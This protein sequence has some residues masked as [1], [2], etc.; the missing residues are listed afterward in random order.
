MRI[1]TTTLC[2]LTG[3]WIQ[4]QQQQFTTNGVF[5]V[6]AGVTSISVELVGPGGNGKV[7]GGGGGGGGGYA[8]GTFAVVPGS[9]LAIVVGSGGSDTATSMASL[10]ISAGAGGNA[11]SVPNPN[12]GGG[13]SGGQG[14]GG[15]VVHDGGAGGGGYWTYFGGG[16]GGAAGPDADGTAGGN[17]VA[18]NGANCLTPGG[19]GGTGGG[20]PAGNGGKGAGF[21]D[22]ACNATNPAG[23]GITYGGGGGGGNGNGG[24]PATGAGGVCIIT[25]DIGTGVQAPVPAVEQLLPS[26][27]HDRLQLFHADGTEHVQ[28]LDMGG[29]ILWSGKNIGQQH[30]GGLPEGIYTVRVETRNAVRC[31]RVV[32]L[33]H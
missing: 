27:F 13:G 6:P 10:G 26:F 31:Q 17:T 23:A 29:R 28:L 2:M 32:K 18:Y 5:R 30:L 7:N 11:N 21:V 16:G 19:T 22:N 33:G 15:Q 25:W 9:T 1:T 4:A 3:L 14:V 12:I 24:E 20:L 8:S